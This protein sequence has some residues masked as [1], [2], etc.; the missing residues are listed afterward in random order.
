[1]LQA[2]AKEGITLIYIYI[3]YFL[4]IVHIHFF[5]GKMKAKYEGFECM[6][7]VSPLYFLGHYHLAIFLFSFETKLS[8]FRAKDSPS[9]FWGI[10]T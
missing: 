7:K 8:P 1:V 3:Y 9:Y 2:K 6:R 4:V 10:V 5:Q